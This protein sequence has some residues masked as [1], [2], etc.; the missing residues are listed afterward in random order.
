MNPH[1]PLEDQEAEAFHRW[2][3]IRGIP[4]THIANESGRGRQAMLRTAK[5]KR[6]GQS[7]GVWDYEIF[8]PQADGSLKEI[9]I[10]LKRRKGGVV[11]PEQKFWGEIYEK[12]GIPH[13][14]CRGWDE[15]REFTEKFMIEDFDRVEF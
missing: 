3:L 11:S 13:K 6:Q 7:K 8:V 5:L 12:A 14:I 15:A 4:H 10:E 9:R 1:N 2:L